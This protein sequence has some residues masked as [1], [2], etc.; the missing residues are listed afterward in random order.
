ML[1]YNHINSLVSKVAKLSQSKFCPNSDLT[2]PN[3]NLQNK[4]LL[5]VL[6]GKT[7]RFLDFLALNQIKIVVKDI[8]THASEHSI[9]GLY[10]LI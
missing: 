9:Y 7:G 1:Y 3:L 8:F 5:R 2:Q 10:F 6:R 4:G